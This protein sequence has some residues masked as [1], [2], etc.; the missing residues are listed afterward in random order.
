MIIVVILPV[1]VK[2]HGIREEPRVPVNLES[3]GHDAGAG[4]VLD[5]LVLKIF[6]GLPR[7]KSEV[8]RLKMWGYLETFIHVNRTVTAFQEPDFN[9][10]KTSI[11]SKTWLH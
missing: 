9:N 3:R 7:C 5:S 10:S 2:L 8:E 6:P 4:L 11:P 1:W